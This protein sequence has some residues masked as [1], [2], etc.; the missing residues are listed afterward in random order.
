[1]NLNK[2]TDLIEKGRLFFYSLFVIYQVFAL[3]SW[4][5]FH[6]GFKSGTN[7]ISLFLILMVLVLGLLQEWNSRKVTVILIALVASYIYYHGY[8]ITG[9]EAL[10]ALLG[11]MAGVS[12][13]ER[14]ILFVDLI[15]RSLSVLAIIILSLVNYLPKSGN[16]VGVTGFFYTQFSYGFLYPNVTA[17]LLGIIFLEIVIFCD[18]NTSRSLILTIFMLLVEI[19][20]NYVTGVA[21]IIVGF[22]YIIYASKI[23]IKNVKILG[24][25]G[26]IG[27]ITLFFVMVYNFSANSTLWSTVDR[28]LSYRLQI[29]TYYLQNW[30]FTM[31]GSFSTENLQYENTI[32][33]GAI[34]GGYIYFILKYGYF[35]LCL[36]VLSNLRAFF[37]KEKSDTLKNILIFITVIIL[38]LI[39]ETSGM[40]LAFSPLYLLLGSISV[41]D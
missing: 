10:F 13:N 1:M 12:L 28:V 30:K 8:H 7:T 17:Y 14:K 32:G 26:L 2:T 33:H 34:D 31:L 11:F 15:T 23:K 18:L 25:V 5:Y 38:T 19:R 24:L 35:F 9:N 20:L 3:S 4:S 39:S 16:G 21:M 40:L 36:F 27:S 41:K 37:T 6:S 29:W 22:I